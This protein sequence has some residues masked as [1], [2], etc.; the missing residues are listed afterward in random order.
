MT[1]INESDY[2]SYL[3]QEIEF[4]EFPRYAAR[5]CEAVDMACAG[6]VPDAEALA[7]FPERVQLR[8]KQAAC[9]QAEYYAL[10]GV[11]AATD[12][13]A[14][15]DGYNI[16]DASVTLHAGSSGGQMAF[17]GGLCEKAYGCL[18]LTGLLYRGCAL[19]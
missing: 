18:A 4:D 7:A 3:G 15:M 19:K 13:S 12:G 6:R 11:E 9:V 16:G 1:W 8:L 10:N 14:A 17:P 2:A 5:A